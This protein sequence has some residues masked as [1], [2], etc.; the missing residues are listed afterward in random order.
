M[1]CSGRGGGLSWRRR[2]AP[3]HDAP[4]NG[5][6][7]WEPISDVLGLLHRHRCLL[8]GSELAL[9]GWALA[10]SVSSSNLFVR[11]QPDRKLRLVD[12]LKRDGKVVAMTGDGVNDA[13]ALT[14]AHVRVAPGKRG[15]DVA[16]EAA[17]VS[18][19]TNTS[20]T[21]RTFLCTDATAAVRPTLRFPCYPTP[22]LVSRSQLAYA[23]IRLASSST[24]SAAT[25]RRA[26]PPGLY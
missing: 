18:A 15:N 12:A 2:Q 14:A 16:S 26:S 5:G 7:C 22:R 1:R 13:P 20:G 25:K 19:S 9:D 17:P 4:A 21:K 24:G 11:F 23:N 10:R 8:L 6:I 3:R